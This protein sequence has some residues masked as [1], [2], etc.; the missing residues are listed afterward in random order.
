MLRTYYVVSDSVLIS[1][2]TIGPGI[3]EVLTSTPSKMTIYCKYIHAN[4]L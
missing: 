2:I 1:D 4:N 3:F